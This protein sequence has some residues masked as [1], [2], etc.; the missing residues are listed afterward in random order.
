M[1]S[2]DCVGI[3]QT[4][5]SICVDIMYNL[6]IPLINCI[7]LIDLSICSWKLLRHCLCCVQALCRCCPYSVHNTQFPD[8]VWME[9]YNLTCLPPSI[10][11]H[12]SLF[13]KWC[14]HPLFI[15]SFGPSREVKASCSLV[16]TCS[17][18]VRLKKQIQWRQWGAQG[19]RPANA[20]RRHF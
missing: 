17:E 18:A 7:Q 9:W 16:D 10:S 15:F 5:S 6:S 12:I 11:L 2:R 13:P 8:V 20:S 4:L 14:Y 1:L 3:V 19:L